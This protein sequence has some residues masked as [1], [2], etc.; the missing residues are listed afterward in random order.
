[1]KAA[2]PSWPVRLTALAA[3]LLV[4]VPPSFAAQFV[5]APV[6]AGNAV[7]GI[8]PIPAPL[9]NPA[10]SPSSAGSLAA[11][12]LGATL[13]TAPTLTPVTASPV[14][15]VPAAVRAQAAAAPALT[16]APAATAAKTLTP[17]S[18]RESLRA[19]VQAIAGDEK[20]GRERPGLAA[21]GSDAAA[22]KADAGLGAQ[23]AQAERFFNLKAGAALNGIHD[24]VGDATAAMA[25]GE[26][27]SEEQ[28]A[29]KGK[30]RGRGKDKG[31]PEKPADPKYAARTLTFNGKEFPSVGF[32]PDRP[33][34]P[35]IIAAID[36]AK[37]TVDIA[38]YE[39]KSREILKALRRA[40][41]R[42]VKVRV[43]IDFYNTFPTKRED[44]SYTPSR[45]L[46]LQ[47]LI[48]EGFDVTVLRGVQKFGIA[49]N[50]L[51]VFDGAFGLFGSY[52]WSYA[53]AEN[54][55]E[56]LAFTDDAKKLSGMKA[57]YEWMRSVS[58]PYSQA[59]DH[60][61]A[62]TV[63]APPRDADPSVEFNGVT[64]PSYAFSPDA[65]V[66]D[67]IVKALGAAK[68]TIDVSMFT[69]TSPKVVRALAAAKQRGVKVR[70]LVDES[71]YGQD[72]MKHFVDWLAWNKIPT[73]TLA[74]PNP[75]GPELLEKD[76]N[77]FGILDGKLVLTG[78]TNWTKSGFATNFEGLYLLDDAADAASYA[79]FFD[80]MFKMRRATR[81]VPP[82]NEP[83][84]PTDEEVLAGLEG[85]PA[86]LPP[87]PQWGPL[88]EART[89]SFNGE[90]LPSAAVRPVH[91][92]KD[93][94]VKA[95]DASKESIHL[96]LYEFNLDDILA[97]LKRAKARGVKVSVILDYGQV[98]PKGSHHDG[99][100]KERSAQVQALID[101]FDVTVLRGVRLPGIMHNKI[102]VF[103][104]KLIEYGS[105][106]WAFTAENHHF[107]NI[108]FED[109]AARVSFYMK[110]WDWMR[111]YSKGLDEAEAWDWARNGPAG[112]PVDE[113]LA[114]E[115]NGTRLPRQAFSPA[116]MVEDSIVKAIQA[117][118]V[119]I[120]VAMFSFYSVRVAEELLAAKER[121]VKVSLL[122]DRMQSKLMKLDD[123]FAY[124]DF[125][126][127]IIAGP[128]PYENVFFEKN[129]NKFML[130]DGKL[131]ETGSY[132]WTGNAEKNSY[133]NVNFTVDQAD[134]AFFTAYFR[135]LFEHGWKPM[136]PKR[137]PSAGSE[138]ASFFSTERFEGSGQSPS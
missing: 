49:H 84:L 34:E 6:S 44:S 31:Q 117:A 133:E 66:E 22:P 65:Q 114:V 1:M 46:E 123:W 120:E 36:A 29:G 58:V 21:L 64:L 32:R 83:P 73:K 138:P 90:T 4:A 48:D 105:Y 130:V 2:R 106:N 95:I 136:K 35:L 15:A 68:E 57:Y 78:S 39:F 60:V 113:D 71:Q 16:A 61:W 18:T 55:F 27:G 88:P 25:A 69:L 9:G 118:K 19:A 98:F 11:P 74:G 37:T 47:S 75:D 135:M 67:V 38:I 99:E 3:A 126:V 51:A 96:A 45:S 24:N 93:I 112:A 13:P 134:V 12:R 124:H 63:P 91:P 129:H 137:P 132:N 125:D 43:I 111:S 127:R 87:G 82:A 33:I 100:A 20:A 131:L 108:K 52:N 10:L 42:G 30:G 59:R 53:S 80:D 76:H 86:P 54:H 115:I 40:K 104:R 97:A 28:A 109:D 17:V 23:S 77:K 110:Y 121:G 50:K 94:L 26:D 119:T 81:V 72:F 70:V 122:L 62:R 101:E 103:D 92:V 41:E 8:T 102:A 89:I 85:D 116:G 128:N 107:E 14:L 5:A 56:N 7:G 79:A